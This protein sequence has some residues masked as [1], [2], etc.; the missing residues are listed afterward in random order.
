MNTKTSIQNNTTCKRGAPHF[1]R[2]RN[3]LSQHI[4][5]IAKQNKEAT[6]KTNKKNEL[7]FKAGERERERE[8]ISK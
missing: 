4:H 3:H 7:T 1:A 6:L 2:L 8:N 5:H